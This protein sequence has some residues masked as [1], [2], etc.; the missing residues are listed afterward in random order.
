[1][2]EGGSLI[3]EEGELEMESGG[4]EGEEAVEVVEWMEESGV[5]E[6]VAIGERERELKPREKGEMDMELPLLSVNSDYVLAFCL[7][8]YC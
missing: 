2:E 6:A 4:L 5:T 1:M 8:I 7:F 3:E